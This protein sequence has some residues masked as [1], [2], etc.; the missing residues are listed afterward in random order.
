MV[1]RRRLSSSPLGLAAGATLIAVLAG[2]P[3]PDVEFED[4][5]KRKD[6]IATSGS[7]SGGSTG[8]GG[9]CAA[10][11]AEDFDG[12]YLLSLVVM[13][14]PDK[15]APFRATLTNTEAEFSLSLQPLHADDRSSDVDSPFMLGP[16]ALNMDGTFEADFGTITIP[17][18]TNPVSGSELVADVVLLGKLCPA[19]F[20]CGKANGMVTSPAPIPLD[21]SDWTMEKLDT[22]MEPPKLNCA[23]DLAAPL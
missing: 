15:P 2:C 6:E 18:D 17:P 22:F 20:L 12:D 5:V 16:F 13:L 11:A 21:G 19:D 14:S 8:V 23:G 3:D 1:Q 9:G 10:P 7:G 4:F